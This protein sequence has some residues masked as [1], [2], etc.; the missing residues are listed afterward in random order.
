MSG[1]R[2]SNFID[3]VGFNGFLLDNM[4]PKIFNL[5]LWSLA[6]FTSLIALWFIGGNIIA[7]QQ[8]Q[9]MN[10][11]KREFFQ[12][13]AKADANDSALKLAELISQLG[14]EP[15]LGMKEKSAKIF[16]SYQADRQAFK[17][18]QSSLKIYLA[19]QLMKPNNDVDIPPEKLR[20]Y[21]KLQEDSLEAIRTHILNNEQPRWPID[22]SAKVNNQSFTNFTSLIDLQRILALEMLERNRQK[23]VKE[24]LQ[25]LE[26]SWQLN[27]A[28]M[29]RPEF[30]SQLVALI[31]ARMQAGVMRKLD[32]VPSEW[33]ER[34]DDFAQ[35]D[36]PK[37]FLRSM[38]GEIR[39]GANLIKD[40]FWETLEGSKI[41]KKDFSDLGDIEK[42]EWLR[43][44]STFDFILQPYFRF[45]A[46]DYWQ[47]M[48]KT[49][50][51]LPKQD[52]CLFAPD[53]FTKEN[54]LLVANWNIPG[55]TAQSSWVKM[56]QNFAHLSL[57]LELTRKILRVKEIAAKNRHW[58]EAIPGISLSHC[59]DGKWI[60]QV[61]ADG[62]MSL[63]YNQKPD[64]L[65][66]KTGL[67]LSYTAKEIEK[68]QK[69]IS[70]K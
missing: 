43:T 36:Y 4:K 21:L 30:M 40:H 35:E 26:V 67:P 59:L 1:F 25:T 23:Q 54:E 17:K 16:S 56:W 19:N 51:E 52:I 24:M 10:V 41:S 46:I 66:E 34:L 13:F 6:G 15:L 63:T 22:L 45:A 53:K 68:E 55:Q 58:S 65:E 39:D 61:S 2:F 33:Q 42:A 47:K 9:E 57:D 70:P 3:Q 18:I 44:L 64:W 49:I 29:A 14:I 31:I 20:Q 27:R 7:S 69:P 32:G 12:Q 28:L 60:Y 48:Q 50:N 8:E 38:N 37:S 11:A 62:I 5:L